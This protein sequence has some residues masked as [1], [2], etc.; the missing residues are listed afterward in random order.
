MLDSVVVD[1]S[2]PLN[3]EK[4]YNVDRPHGA[5][6]GRATYGPHKQGETLS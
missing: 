1:D 2:E 6:A 4:N 5:P 3:D